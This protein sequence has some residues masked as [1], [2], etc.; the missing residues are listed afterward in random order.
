MPVLRGNSSYS[1]SHVSRLRP[2]S[3]CHVPVYVL[4]LFCHLSHSL[5]AL[6]P[7]F[8]ATATSSSTSSFFRCGS[9]TEGPVL[10]ITLLLFFRDYWIELV[11]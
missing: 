4:L 11:L 5:P 10:I 8:K 6:G 1:C 9:K 3:H 2:V 7:P